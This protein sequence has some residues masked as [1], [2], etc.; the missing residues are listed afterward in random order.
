MATRYQYQLFNGNAREAP[1]GP[2]VPMDMPYPFNIGDSYVFGP[3]QAAP[4]TKVG[5]YI[6]RDATGNIIFSTLVV[7]SPASPHFTAVSE[8]DN[9]V[10]W[11]TSK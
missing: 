3:N 8:G 5:H 10:P 7:I 2:P 1:M 9:T 4:I 6:T 11:P